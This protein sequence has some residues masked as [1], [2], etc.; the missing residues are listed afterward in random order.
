MDFTKKNDFIV[1]HKSP[2]HFE[3]DLELFKL[4]YPFSKLHNEL[5]RINSFNRHIL[6]G[7]ILFEL[8]DK[9]S[10]D[11]ILENRKEKAPD[12]VIQNTKEVKEI[13]LE[14]GIPVETLSDAS[15]FEAIGKTRVE[16]DALLDI[17]LTHKKEEEET[18]L[19]IDQ[20]NAF[21]LEEGIEAD[22]LSAE[23]L[24]SYVGKKRNEV[25][26]ILTLMKSLQPI[27]IQKDESNKIE[28]NSDPSSTETD[29]SVSGTPESTE[30]ESLETG[31]ESDGTSANDEHGVPFQTDAVGDESSE[32][33]V[34]DPKIS[35]SAELKKKERKPRSSRK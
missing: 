23:I 8:L 16:F 19:N 12:P 1:K 18:L 5:T 11:A 28:A 24:L 22:H 35:V 29:T 25:R 31:N 34:S 33:A 32:P 10:A 26:E 4:H 20:V 27:T 30:G 3:K 2:E 15:L 13:L 21:F 9:I 6:H 17:Y 14:K 7:R